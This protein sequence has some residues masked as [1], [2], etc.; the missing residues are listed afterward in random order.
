MFFFF[1]VPGSYS[2]THTVFTCHFSLFSYWLQLFLSIFCLLMTL[3]LPKISCFSKCSLL[4]ACL[5]FLY[6]RTEFLLYEAIWK[7]LDSEVRKGLLGKG[8]SEGGNSLGPEKLY[9]YIM[10]MQHAVTGHSLQ[11]TQT[12]GRVAC[13]ELAILS[14]SQIPSATR[15]H[16]HSS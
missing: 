7:L 4:Q 6:G 9:T 2:E 15:R 14:P 12:T 11:K 5:V 8:R 16:L 3:T 13:P 1:F 10:H